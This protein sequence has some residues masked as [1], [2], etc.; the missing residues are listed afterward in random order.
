MARFVDLFALAIVAFLLLCRSRRWCLRPVLRGTKA[1]STASRC[2]KIRCIA[3]QDDRRNRRRAGAMRTCASS[4]RR[5]RLR[6]ASGMART[7]S[8]QV[9]QVLAT[10]YVQPA[11]RPGTW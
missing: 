7:D 8:Y 10:A 9:H 4:S 6:P 11:F 1:T 5:G 3:K 2:S